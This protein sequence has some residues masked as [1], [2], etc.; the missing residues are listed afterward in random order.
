MA[1]KL[2]LIEPKKYIPLEGI[3]SKPGHLHDPHRDGRT[4]L[5]N[6]VVETLWWMRQ[7]LVD[8]LGP[9]DA[10][11]IWRKG[12]RYPDDP[13]KRFMYFSAVIKDLGGVENES[14]LDLFAKYKTKPVGIEQFINAAYYLNKKDEIYPIVLAELIE[15]NSGKYVELVLTGGIGSA[16]TTC[17]LYTNLY[18][19]YLLSCMHSPHKLYGL[20]TSSEILLIFQSVNKELAKGVDYQRFKAMVDGSP[21]FR[22]QFPYDKKIESSLRFANRV[23]V[24]PVSGAEIATLG[25][26]VIGGLIDE[27][28]YM[29]LVEKSKQ[30]V[31]KGTYDQAVTLYNSI[32]RRRKT[33]FMEQGK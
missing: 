31:D 32:S 5:G 4:P 22:E 21:Y 20:D 7:Y 8:V 13:I 33:R 14:E 9:E 26:N 17:A 30:S 15:M 2:Q 19:L 11:E 24:K 18:Q 6:T 16:K 25:Q 27:L 3:V 23:E 12:D 1:L 10:A 29:N 28:N